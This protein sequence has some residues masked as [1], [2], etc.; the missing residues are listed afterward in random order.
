MHAGGRQAMNLA[1]IEE[2]EST[3][4]KT[5]LEGTSEPRNPE[6]LNLGIFLC[7]I[8]PNAKRGEFV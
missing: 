1:E 2:A 3:S 7:P 4:S 8:H 6:P 5:P